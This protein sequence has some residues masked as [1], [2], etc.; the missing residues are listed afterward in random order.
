MLEEILRDMIV[1]FQKDKLPQLFLRDLEIPTLPKEIRKAQIFVGMRR[2]GKTYLMFQHMKQALACGLE[3]EKILYLN[4]EDDRLESFKAEDFQKILDVYFEIHPHLAQ[5]EDL[6]FYFDEIQNVEGWEKF[7]R[8]LID[9]EKMSIFITGSS[10]KSLS[11]DISTSL[12][13]RCLETEVF[14]LGFV[15]YLYYQGIKDLKNP[16]AKER[17]TIKHHCKEYLK[18]G[19]F[20]ETLSLSDTLHHRLI[21]SYVNAAVFRDV[22]DRHKLNNPHIVKLFLNHCLQSIAAPLSITKV[23]NDFK[24]RGE[25]L[26][27]ARLYEYLSYFED[28]YLIYNVPLFDLSFRKRQV[29]PSKIYCVDPGIIS[30]YSVT[31]QTEEGV[32]L[33]N[34]VY[35]HLR[36][37][38]Y[39]GIYYYKTT[40][41]KKVDFVTQSAKGKIELFQACLRLDSPKTADREYSALIE[42]AGEL[43]LSEAFIIT[44][45]TAEVIRRDDVTLHVIPYWKWV[46]HEV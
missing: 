3:M 15:E 35:L 25:T 10:A 12:R 20:P 39:E 18:R 37:Q 19:G 41:G 6:I 5:A 43:K 8:R 23:F 45:D 21:Q 34:T 31:P 30:A 22:I 16:P 40:Q 2:V 28:A 38:G 14:P 17:A 32:S 27:R 26:T 11:R 29:N 36:K 9:R 7:I 13:G 24:S 46:T 4:F 42:A 33:E 1:E 44:L